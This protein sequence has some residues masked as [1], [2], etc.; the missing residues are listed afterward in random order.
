M[1]LEP[2]QCRLCGNT[3]IRCLGAIPNS[4]FFAGRVLKNSIDGG[5]L[6]GC[7]AC[8]SM[9]RH[10]ILSNSA[11]L[12]LYANG[13]AEEWSTD[14]GR[15]DLAIIREI[16]A[17]KP[18]TKRIL[19]IGCGSGAFL[20]SL[21]ANVAKFG[22]EPSM[23]AAA[24][25]RSQ[26]V[27]I[28]AS[29]LE[30]TSEKGGFDVVTIIDVIEHVADPEELLDSA[31]RQLAPGGS[32]IIA[33]G[34]VGHALWRRV[35]RSR[36]WYSSFPE[37]ITFPSIEFFELWCKGKGLGSPSA[38]RLR[39]RPMPPW[40]AALYSISQVVYLASPSLLNGIGRAINWLRRAPPPRRRFFS[41]AAP[42]VFTDHQVVTLHNS[43]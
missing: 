41:P 8:Q 31:V 7:D 17:S 10:P 27:S 19:D 33:T 28:L 34:D 26:G 42:G 12:T 39:Y 40:Q 29:T 3:R 38:V 4:D 9:F 1:K 21:P 36:F 15:K 32:L 25:A 13:A 22:V 14:E 20:L 43:P 5:Y 11:Y 2:T 18:G 16:I 6:W 37:H 23:A 24:A 35:F 30:E